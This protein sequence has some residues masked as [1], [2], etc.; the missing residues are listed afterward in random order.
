MKFYQK[1][2]NDSFSPIINVTNITLDNGYDSQ[3]GMV[4]GIIVD[5]EVLSKQNAFDN[6]LTDNEY[7][8]NTN[9]TFI[10]FQDQQE[11]ES[12]VQ[13]V[14]NKTYLNKS[15]PDILNELNINKYQNFSLSQIYSNKSED[16]E[17][18]SQ[19]FGQEQVLFTNLDSKKDVVLYVIPSIDFVKFFSNNQYSSDNI[20]QLINEFY[21]IEWYVYSILL[22]N[23]TIIDKDS[24]RILN[25]V[26]DFKEITTNLFSLLPSKVQQQNIPENSSYVSDIFTSFD[27]EKQ[28]IRS[29]FFFEIK[30]FIKD[31]SIFDKVYESLSKDELESLL[32]SSTNKIINFEIYKE[33]LINEHLISLFNTSYE[34]VVG[35]TNVQIIESLSNDDRVCYV[36]LDNFPTTKK[37]SFKYKI[38]VTFQDAL[39]KYYYDTLTTP[40]SG[41]FFTIAGKINEIENFVNDPRNSDAKTGKFVRF[42]TGRNIPNI[43]E[44][45]NLFVKMLN[46]FLKNPINEN[47]K[48]SIIKALNYN[49]STFQIHVDFVFI[50][51]QILLQIESLF[52]SAGYTRQT[53]EKYSSNIDF[54]NKNYYFKVQDF[55]VSSVTPTLSTTRQAVSLQPSTKYYTDG[56]IQ[57]NLLNENF[58]LDLTNEVGFKVVNALINLEREEI[59]YSSENSLMSIISEQQGTTIEKIV[60]LQEK[61]V[62]KKPISLFAKSSTS[63]DTVQSPASKI[64]NF[65][66]E[67]SYSKQQQNSNSIQNLV[68]NVKVQNQVDTQKELEF[69]TSFFDNMSYDVVVP[70]TKTQFYLPNK[71]EWSDTLNSNTQ[72]NTYLARTIYRKSGDI[73]T[74]KDL[75]PPLTNKY[76]IFKVA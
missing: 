6:W 74:R 23:K 60:S 16:S 40:S 28:Q 58:N 30:K 20:A 21:S 22:K 11:I 5:F 4:N 68:N 46:L 64:T 13:E 59:T 51:K 34:K 76:F 3:S 32:R 12:F 18:N 8:D 44:F 27:Y 49:K 63:N 75:E 73:F 53:Y 56:N 65:N 36:M 29:F 25:D 62:S 33:T 1:F 15:I 19:L 39:L 35:S 37:E 57:Y 71:N 55:D 52:L 41:V 43:T 26:R 38:N 48:N 24:E 66:K 69:Q 54:V 50:V 45:V 9:I 2:G 10:V 31:K 61:N 14:Q 17:T 67:N 7:L 72:S 42:N 70:K 47:K